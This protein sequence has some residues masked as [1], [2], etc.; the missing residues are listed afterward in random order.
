MDSIPRSWEEAGWK[1]A[2]GS[3]S[4]DSVE[5]QTAVEPEAFR[6]QLPTG[7]LDRIRE[8]QLPILQAGHQRGS[9]Q[10]RDLTLRDKTSTKKASRL[11][12]GLLD[13][14]RDLAADCLDS[15]SAMARCKA[16]A[17]RVSLVEGWTPVM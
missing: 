10:G 1:I 3:S 13:G 15:L 6:P 2:K 8:S 4:H 7:V 14:S 9:L 5:G 17:R 11:E 16:A 12:F